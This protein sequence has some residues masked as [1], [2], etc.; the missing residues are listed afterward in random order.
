ALGATRPRTMNEMKT[1]RRCRA[2][3]DVSEYA[4]TAATSDGLAKRCAPCQE[5]VRQVVAEYMRSD[6]EKRC[7]GC[8]EILP[9]DAFGPDARATD[10]RRR[11]CRGCVPAKRDLRTVN[12][13]AAVHAALLEAAE[14]NSCTLAE[15]L[16]LLVLTAPS[17]LPKRI[18]TPFR[19]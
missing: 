1:C 15:A 10:G 3:L 11:R 17:A 13:S 4:A 18:A 9:L 19:D 12:V 7:L 16:A 6:V 2:E 5:Q 8:G 14:G